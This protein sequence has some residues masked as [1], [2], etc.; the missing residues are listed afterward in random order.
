MAPE[1]KFETAAK[2]C[3]EVIGGFC[4]GQLALEEASEVLRDALHILGSPHIKV[5]A[6]RDHAASVRDCS[7][8][9][10]SARYALLLGWPQR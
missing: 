10:A 6:M 3:K 7:V 5:S 1:H 4:E 8:W 9:L 2:L